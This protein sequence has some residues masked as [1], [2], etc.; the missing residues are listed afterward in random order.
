MRFKDILSNFYSTFICFSFSLFIFLNFFP[1]ETPPYPLTLHHI[2]L[3][4]IYTSALLL[5]EPAD[6][7][8]ERCSRAPRGGGGGH[9]LPPQGKPRQVQSVPEIL[10]KITEP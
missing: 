6:S 5:G 3:H 4:N 2:I 8:A 7:G 9:S 10:S 1:K